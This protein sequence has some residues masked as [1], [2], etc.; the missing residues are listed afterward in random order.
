MVPE[1]LQTLCPQNG[2]GSGVRE[3]LAKELET[4]LCA[5]PWGSLPALT[6]SPSCLHPPVP[7]HMAPVASSQLWDHTEGKCQ[8]ASLVPVFGN[9][10]LFLALLEP[11]LHRRE[12]VGSN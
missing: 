12:I 9:T 6:S 4:K 7:I 1:I 8:Q 5:H 11:D 3:L 10:E 2:A